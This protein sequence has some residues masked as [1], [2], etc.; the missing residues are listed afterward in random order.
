MAS[1]IDAST[2]GAGGV[3]TTA[4]N[5][6]ILQLKSGGTTIATISSTGVSTQVGAPAFYAYATGNTALTSATFTK[7]A[8]AAER[9]DTNSNYSTVDSRFTP[10]VAGY[11]NITV[12]LD[13]NGNSNTTT[14]QIMSI[15]KNGTENVRLMDLRIS[16]TNDT[17]TSGSALI[18]MNGTTDYVEPYGYMIMSSGT[19]VVTYDASTAITF[20]SAFLAR[21]A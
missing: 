1:S 2:S 21:S 15:Y 3:I 8:M 20:F 9:F 11:Y 17:I 7:I 14:R 13:F 5:T 10:T 4:D 12:S 19:G 18:Y 6:G 16:T